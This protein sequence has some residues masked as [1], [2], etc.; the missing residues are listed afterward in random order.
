MV[1][2]S[3]NQVRNLRSRYGQAGNKDDRFDAFVVADTL[4]TDR[5]WLRAPDP[6]APATLLLRTAVRAR[7][8][9]VGHRVA[10]ANQ[11]RAYLNAFYPAP[12]GLLHE[13]DGQMSIKFLS[14]F[15]CQ[16]RADWLTP[17]RVASFLAGIRY[18]G[19]TTPEKMHARIAAV[20]RGATGDVGAA[21]VHVTRALL[22]A[23]RCVVEQIEVLT[24][25]ITEHV[26]AHV[27]T[28]LPCAG[29]LRAARL[30]AEIGDAG[31][32]PNP[33]GAR[34]AG[35]GRAVDPAIG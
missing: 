31:P 5:Q 34:L 3:P 21:A 19:S 4:C 8:D 28:S 24:D 18:C 1:V 32:V 23:L 26:D 10:L 25:Q 30:L 33:G 22:S 16:D 2:I 17:K 6:D 9:L 14:R 7:K 12:V 20:P 11:L 15:D 27:V 35:R 13:L 29:T